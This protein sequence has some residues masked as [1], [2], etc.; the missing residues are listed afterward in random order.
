M[1]AAT[2]T[3]SEKQMGGFSIVADEFRRYLLYELGR[4]IDA[5]NACISDT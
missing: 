5:T 3:S 2:F 4:R 1:V